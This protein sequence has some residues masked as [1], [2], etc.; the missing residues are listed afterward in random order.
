MSDLKNVNGR[1]GKVK[2]GE[3]TCQT[4]KGQSTIDY[5]IMSME[6]FPKTSDFYIDTL[7]ACMSDV[8]C[9]VCIVFFCE[10]AV[11]TKYNDFDNVVCDR[12]KFVIENNVMCKWDAQ[13]MEQYTMEFDVDEINILQHQFI[14][15][16]Q[17][18]DHVTQHIV[19]S[20]YINI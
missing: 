3:Y 12:S 19:D 18:I 2:Y 16:L 14:N 15:V 17:G 9:P 4:K 10:D 11:I 1:I 20:L 5:A 7:N 6:L 13:L 8:N